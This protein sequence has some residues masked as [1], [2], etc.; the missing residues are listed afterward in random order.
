[1]TCKSKN[2]AFHGASELRKIMPDGTGNTM[3]LDFAGAN[4]S[5]PM[6][7]LISDGTFLYGMTS[8]S[9]TPGYGSI[10]KIMSDG[11]GYDKSL[12][13]AAA[14]NGSQPSVVSSVKCR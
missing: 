5:N 13:F 8:L 4:G 3:L 11:T 1:M 12:D 6:G 9:G 14:A 10:F 7:S 2:Y